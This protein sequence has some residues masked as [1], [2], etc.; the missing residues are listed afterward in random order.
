MKMIMNVYASMRQYKN[1]EKFEKGAREL[2]NKAFKENNHQV[3]YVSFLNILGDNYLKIGG[4]EGH[5]K[6]MDCYQE[7]SWIL[8]EI[9]GDESIDFLLSL[10]D[11]GDVY[12]EQKEFDKAK[13]FYL[14]SMDKITTLYGSNSIFLHWVNAALVELYTANG[15][16]FKSLYSSLDN[17]RLA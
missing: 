12:L 7:A 8:A 13:S 11:I 16:E 3:E 17:L 2:Y 14:L 10:I 9:C 5:A 6:A 15:G 1:S 4:V